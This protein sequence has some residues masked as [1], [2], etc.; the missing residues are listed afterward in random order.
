MLE[1]RRDAAKADEDGVGR[2]IIIKI[3]QV[4]QVPNLRNLN[5]L[6]NL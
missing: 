1:D 2:K 5:I 3:I 4:S 6:I